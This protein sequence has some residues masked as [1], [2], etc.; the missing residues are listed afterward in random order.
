[1]SSFTLKRHGKK[2][3]MVADMFDLVVKFLRARSNRRAG[4]LVARM[5]LH[6]KYVLRFD[7]RLAETLRVVVIEVVSARLM[8]K[9]DKEFIREG[10]KKFINAMVKKC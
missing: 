4:V 3:K 8:G 2:A 7:K 1:M 6:Y 9:S 10:I 5:E